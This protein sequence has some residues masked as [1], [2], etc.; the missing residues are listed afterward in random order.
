MCT[1]SQKRLFEREDE[2][3]RSNKKLPPQK[4]EKRHDKETEKRARQE[5]ARRPPATPEETSFRHGNWKYKRELVRK[6][7]I[8]A[9][10]STN[11]LELFENCG[12]DCIAEYCVE[13]KRYRLRANYCKNRHCE[14]CNRSKANLLAANLRKR[15]EVEAKGRYRFVTLTLKHT[16]TP[17]R[18]QIDRL[19]SC[20]R[21]LRSHRLWKGSQLGGAAILEVKWSPDTGEWHPH[22]H[23]ISE[24]DF[25]HQSDLASIWYKVTGDSHQVDIRAL[26]TKKDA[27]YY[28]SKYVSKGT[29]IEV[30]ENRA[31]A[32]EWITAMR[33]TRT[34]GC[35]GSWRALKLLAHEPD[36]GVWTKVG[37]LT[38]IYQAA[39][40]GS[41]W[42]IRALEAITRDLRYDPHKK[43]LKIA[44]TQ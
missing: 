23:L 6:A 26:D 18:E 36:S 4:R 7:L 42:A 1:A 5:A 14:P 41:E 38:S 33:S 21:K 8:A 3:A 40:D 30:W 22:L 28:V 12:G 29:N 9:N 15:L 10:A 19:Y 2:I 27:A 32:A 24:G 39:A 13:E 34:C 31:A 43:R 16:D 35:Y 17:L 25:L 11:S 20:F 37:T 44:P